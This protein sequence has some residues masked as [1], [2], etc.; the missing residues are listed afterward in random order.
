MEL[1]ELRV[2]DSRTEQ[3]DKN[4]VSEDEATE[5]LIP[6]SPDHWKDSSKRDHGMFSCEVDTVLTTPLSPPLD[7]LSLKNR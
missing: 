5:R 3:A 4:S 7:D 1:D 2:D 6:V